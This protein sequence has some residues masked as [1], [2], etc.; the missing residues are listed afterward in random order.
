[1]GRL[2]PAVKEFLQDLSV[3][4]FLLVLKAL[5]CIRKA[6]ACQLVLWLGHL[7]EGKIGCQIF[8]DTASHW[9]GMAYAWLSQV[10]GSKQL[11][12]LMKE[13][14]VRLRQESGDWDQPNT[15][16]LVPAPVLRKLLQVS[17]Q[18]REKQKKLKKRRQL[19]A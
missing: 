6:D 11:I 8:T 15:R 10:I 4:T 2:L 19:R 17:K 13:K 7:E 18:E 3:N 14:K 16:R 5:G 1:M 12:K 9:T